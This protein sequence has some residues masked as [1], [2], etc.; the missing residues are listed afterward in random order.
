MATAGASGRLGRVV[1][2]G[3]IAVCVPGWSCGVWAAGA[4]A[5]PWKSVKDAGMG[6][7][8]GITEVVDADAAYFNPAALSFLPA[9]ELLAGAEWIDLNVHV[10]GQARRQAASA[11]TDPTYVIGGADGRNPAHDLPQLPGL[12]GAWRYNQR[13]VLGAALNADGLIYRYPADWVG[14]YQAIETVLRLPQLDLAFGFR[15]APQLA[16]GAGLDLQY[17]DARLAND[18][19]LGAVIELR[20][21]AECSNLLAAAPAACGAVVPHGKLGGRYDFS[22]ALFARDLALGWHAG[23]LWQPRATTRIGLAYRSAIHHRLR[24]QAL[25]AR[26]GNGW[27]GTPGWNAD[28]LR[29]DP[30][31]AR[32]RALLDARRLATGQP[33]FDQLVVQP[34]MQ[35]S[36]DGNFGSGLLVPETIALGLRQAL[37]S[38]WEAALAWSWTRWSRLRELTASFDDGRD[39]VSRALRL[40]NFARYSLGLEY[41][42]NRTLALRAGAALEDGPDTPGTRTART[43]DG[44]RRYLTLGLGL[45]ARS[46]LGLDLAVS[47]LSAK[48]GPLHD[49]DEVS[50]DVLDGSIDRMRAWA[51]GAQLRWQWGLA[52]APVE[53]GVEQRRQAQR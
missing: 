34:A 37:G 10:S 22:N 47:Y 36:S 39:P 7:A 5:L 1:A 25:H 6:F 46:G 35:A 33:G 31:L 26:F 52:G 28:E 53:L 24:G 45:T 16:L 4:F 18:V 3:L 14:R 19:D 15:L 51:V 41:H 29:S 9:N 44:V 27:D 32:L 30:D 43:P 42:P 13:L 50:G 48:G 21:A 8:S 38:D 2:R 23:L 20:A 40:R 17:A 49:V 11:P 12:Y